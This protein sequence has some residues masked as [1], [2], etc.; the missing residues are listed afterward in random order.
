METNLK[1]K[2]TITLILKLVI[3]FLLFAFLFTGA[4]NILKLK[5]GH[6]GTDNVKGF[7]EI[8]EKSV[9]VLF[10]GASTCFCTVDPLELYEDHG[11][12]SYDFT[13]SVQPFE[14]SLLFMEEAMKTQKPK[15]IGLELLSLFKELDES[16]MDNLNYGLTDLPFS[17]TKA[18]GVADMF[19]DD[20]GTGLAY[21]IPMVQYKDRW[22]ELTKED[23]KPWED[24]LTMGAYTPDTISEEPIDFSDYGDEPDTKD[25]PER[26]REI[27]LRM[28][29]LCKKNDIELFCFKS[30]NVGWKLGETKGAR[31]ICEE[32]GIPFIDYFSLMDE[33]DIDA[34]KDFRDTSH[35]NRTGSEKASEYMGRF[36]KENYSLSDERGTVRGEPWKRALEHRNAT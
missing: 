26:N 32:F 9:D 14:L 5:M 35:L 4:Q 8:P 34:S 28:L 21:L 25:V 17:L 2:N 16:N 23:I 10:I 24:P 31:A 29:D 11:I 15:V 19:R 1:A 3:F 27:F 7:Y 20:L 33:L 12:T 18:K 6:R 30:P 13:S 36:L 22:Q